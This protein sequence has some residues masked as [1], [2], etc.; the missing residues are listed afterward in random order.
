MLRWRGMPGKRGHA[1]L[2]T[3]AM[4]RRASRKARSVERNERDVEPRREDVPRVLQDGRNR[5][6]VEQL[7]LRNVYT[8]KKQN[9][10]E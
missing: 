4:S 3:S 6:A 9:W 10:R 8:L 2:T 7:G 5:G 1:C